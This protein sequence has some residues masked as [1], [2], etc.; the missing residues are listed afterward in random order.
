MQEEM[1]GG[2]VSVGGDEVG[3]ERVSFFCSFDTP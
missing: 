3:G 2:G 1:R